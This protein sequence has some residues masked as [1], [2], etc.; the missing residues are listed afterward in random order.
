[1]RQC[2]AGLAG[3]G[4]GQCLRTR[5]NEEMPRVPRCD[6][7]DQWAP[8]SF[9][10]LMYYAVSRCSSE[11]A[12]CVPA[13]RAAIGMLYKKRASISGAEMGCRESRRACSMAAGG[14]VAALNGTNE[15]IENAAEI[16]MEHNL[17]LTCDPIAAWSRSVH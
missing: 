7:A 6:G 13:D 5:V 15:Q 9:G 14:L 17:G 10:V 2:T 1:V 3:D 12:C 4:L 11:K 8:V 16:G